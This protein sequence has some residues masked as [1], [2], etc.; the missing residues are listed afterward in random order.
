MKTM[1]HCL[2]S[3]YATLVLCVLGRWIDRNLEHMK[4]FG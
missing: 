4:G 2:Y 3:I 1:K